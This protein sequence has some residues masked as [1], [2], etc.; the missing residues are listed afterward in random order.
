MANFDRSGMTQAGIN[1]MGKAVGG[2]TIQFTRLVLGDGT[3]TGEILDLQGVVSPKQ[4]VDVTRI[5][6]N[7]SQC[8]VGGELLTSSIKQGFFWRECGL[9]AMDPDQGEILYNYAYSTKPDYI[10]ASDSGMMEEI[11][12]SMVT[13]VGSNTNVDV[14]IDDSM[15][16][17]TKREVT[18]IQNKT[19]SEFA[20]IKYSNGINAVGDGVVDDS[21]A[22][23]KIINDNAGKTVYI[24]SGTYLINTMLTVPPGTKIIGVGSPTS[25]EYFKV[26]FKK[27]SNIESVF[28][29][30]SCNYIEL[31]NIT[32]DG[33]GLSGNG[34]QSQKMTYSCFKNV[35]IVNL[36]EGAGFYIT[37]QLNGGSYANSF[38]NCTVAECK[39]GY[40]L[41]TKT[42]ITGEINHMIFTNC[43][44][45]SCS[46]YGF[47]II[48]N[49]PNNGANN[50]F[51]SCDSE[52]NEYGFYFE[53]GGKSNSVK[54]CYIEYNNVGIH[55]EGSQVLVQAITIEDNIINGDGIKS[56]TPT[57]V[58]V[59][60]LYNECA[61]LKG[62]H[63][64]YHAKGVH[65]GYY[66]KTNTIITNLIRFNTV[67]ILDETKIKP[68]MIDGEQLNNAIIQKS[69]LLRRY[70]YKN[71]NFTT[72]GKEDF[73]LAD[74]VNTNVTITL[75]EGMGIGQC[76]SIAK[77]KDNGN[78][79]I[80]THDE[81]V[82]IQGILNGI[83]VDS[84]SI[85]FTTKGAVIELIRLDAKLYY[86]KSVNTIIQQA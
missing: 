65:I 30:V 44:A 24:P 73:I 52:N 49:E 27:G 64:S 34:I 86:I 66:S 14:T 67:D 61:I 25:K 29:L 39:D 47:G 4:N 1:L 81:S 58:G 46:R 37:N 79:I 11:L 17:A 63:I 36:P 59:E 48:S 76:I 55:V 21:A 72:T 33:N 19:Y 85:S 71:T 26:V 80:Q 41:D 9:Y 40:V 57:T 54:D 38:I 10:A 7:D 70:A 22:I 56:G 60:L 83:Y 3:M 42:H 68:L 75:H 5:E 32:I 28:N 69:T 77:Q 23:Q 15:V 84:N 35:T 51:I 78:I 20:N 43:R 18:L 45:L 50:K 82:K 62:N 6:R 13:T 16:F 31:E 53:N 12:V 74:S 2:A 8:T